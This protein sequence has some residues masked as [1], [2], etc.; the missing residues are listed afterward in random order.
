MARSQ[1]EIEELSICKDAQIMIEKAEKDGV[2][3]VWDR[4]KAQQ[5]QCTFCKQGL[6]CRNCSMGPCRIVPGKARSLGVCGANA[7]TI[8]AR[9]FG[10]GVAAGAAAHSD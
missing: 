5:P 3:T 2:V 7:D 10:R 1:D 9:N 4:F 6:S 8:V